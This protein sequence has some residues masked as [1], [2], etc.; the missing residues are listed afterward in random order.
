PRGAGRILDLRLC[1]W[2]QFAP[3]RTPPVDESFPAR[4][5]DP[6]GQ[7]RLGHAGLFEI[8][9][10]VGLLPCIQPGAG[11]FDGVAVGDAIDSQAHCMFSSI[12]SRCTSWVTKPSAVSGIAR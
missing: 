1:R 2:R 10:L 8:V 4:L 6:L 3:G 12:S 5:G 7:A 9:E 11:F